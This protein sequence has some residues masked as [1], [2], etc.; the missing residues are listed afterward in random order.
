MAEDVG[1]QAPSFSATTDE[2][3]RVSLEDFRGRTLVLYF[4]PR[5]DTAG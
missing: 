4:Y 5:A 2:G 3:R 1:E